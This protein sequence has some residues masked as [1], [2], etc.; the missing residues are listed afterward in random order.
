MSHGGIRQGLL[1]WPAASDSYRAGFGLDGVTV[2]DPSTLYRRGNDFL[3]Q[4]RPAEA[5]ADFDAALQAVGDHPDLLNSRGIA[6]QMLERRDR[7]L[8]DF[9]RAVALAPGNPLLH[10]NRGAVLTEMGRHQD[11]AQ[12]LGTAARLDPGNATTQHNFGNVLRTLDRTVEALAAYDRALA[13][14]PNYV[15]ALIARG[16]ASV[17]LHRLDE[18]KVNLDHALALAP[19]HPKAHLNAAIRD[20]LAGDLARGF[21]GYEWRWRNPPN[22]DWARGFAQ[23]LWLGSEDIAGKTL[24][25][26]AEQGLGDTL[27]F[28]R[29]AAV[30]ARRGAR[31][32]LEVQKPLVRLLSSLEGVAAIVAQGDALP[33]FDLHCPL[34]SLPLALGGIPHDVP[35]IKTPPSGW[36]TPLPPGKRIGLSWSGNPALKN[37][38]HR[39]IALARFAPLLTGPSIISVQKDLRPE[40]A[41]FAAGR[42][43]HYGADLHDFADTAALISAMDVVVTVDTAAAH[44]AGA[45]GKP[46]YILLPYIGVDWRWGIAGDTTPW[47]PTARLLR[48]PEPGDWDSVIARLAA[49]LSQ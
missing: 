37:D 33:A 35:Y 4:G 3:A 19:D 49:E 45:M 34:M 39:S 42:I 29:Y 36:A 6:L 40:D 46:V 23:P 41:A 5:L 12:S 44:L 14:Q 22:S 16:L 47:Y 43:A 10:A 28:C 48:Q 31:V 15:D 8:A 20:L 21:A 18:A 17:D 38:R 9:E 11:A 7:A 1:S 26:H 24:L 30:A 27:H 2:P 13:L 32:V 25:L